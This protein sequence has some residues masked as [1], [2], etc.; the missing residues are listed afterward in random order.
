MIP[1]GGPSV[2]W[3]FLEYLKDFMIQQSNSKDE[4]SDPVTQDDKDF[5]LGWHPDSFLSIHTS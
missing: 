4:I 3:N 2:R 1:R 5:S